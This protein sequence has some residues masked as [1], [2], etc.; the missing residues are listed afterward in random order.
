MDHPFIFLFMKGV[1]L[2]GNVP[3]Y[4]I[5]I[6]IAFPLLKRRDWLSFM[7]I[8]VLSG[9]INELL[10]NGF[11]L[12]R[13]SVEH[14]KISVAGY[15]FP[16]G[17]AQMAVVVWGW[18]GYRYKRWISALIV[19]FFI[20]VSRIYLGVHFLDQ[21]FCGWLIGFFILGI[22]IWKIESKPLEE[23]KNKDGV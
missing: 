21:V 3:L 17:H 16:S 5:Y 11:A 1:T 10:K 4:F 6:I 9:I 18:L 12:P 23:T 22:W 8:I 15:G 13:P 14:H 7:G 20:G 2:L 19:I